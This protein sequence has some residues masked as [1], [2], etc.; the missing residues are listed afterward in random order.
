MKKYSI[1]L[2]EYL[3][4]L[5][6]SEG[7]KRTQ[8]ETEL[9]VYRVTPSMCARLFDEGKVDISLCPVG[10]LHDLPA[11]EIRGRYCIG[12]D[13]EVG[14]VMLLS[15][16]PLS[17]ITSVR[18]DDH[19]RT[20]NLLLQILAARLWDKE[21]TYSLGAEDSLPQS[22]LMIG[23]N[24]F[25]YR[26]EYPYRYDLAAAWKELTGLPMVFAVWI[27]R[28]GVPEELIRELDEAFESGFDFVKSADSGLEPWQTD[29]LIHNISYPLDTA[30][31]EAMELYLSWAASLEAVHVN[32]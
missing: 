14:T 3:N 25:T 29:Y 24:V 15:K 1:A 28:P 8:L 12:A 22:C 5:P 20:S 30:K 27:T 13:G 7:I 21:W 11:H 31:R 17:E 26:D 9:N 19:S 23:D 32:L 4:T 18:L 2:V 10:A 16:V 6:F